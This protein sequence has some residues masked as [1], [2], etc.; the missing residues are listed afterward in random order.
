MEGLRSFVL[1]NKNGF[2][3][4]ILNWGATLT[5]LR[6][7]DREGIP[8]AVVIGFPDPATYLTNEYLQH[9]MYLGSS[10]GRFAGRIGHNRFHL[11]GVVCQLQSRGAHQLHGGTGGLS[12]RIWEL[13]AY[14][15]DRV[16]LKVVSPH[17]EGGYPG[18][19]AVQVEYR[20]TD[21]S[22][23]IDY[24]ATTD[25]ATVV[26]LT[27]HAYFNL[28]GGGGLYGDR[29]QIAA[30]RILETDKDLIPTGTILAVQD[31]EHDYR[32]DKKLEP[33]FVYLD[34]VFVLNDTDTK[35]T[36]ISGKSGIRMQV[37]TKQPGLVVYT[38][39]SMP[40]L[41]YHEGQIP[42]Q[43]GA[44]CFECQGFPDAPNKESFPS[45]R[46]MPHDTYKNSIRYRFD[47]Q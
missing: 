24:T 22:L 5:D 32:E 46:L 33:G 20:L 18:N 47:H 1:T 37:F 43:L 31:T 12:E 23:E 27:N 26:N 19:L 36:Y 28:S 16:T 9:T 2:Q 3:A 13:L 40:D 6:V 15:S 25:R 4:S 29:L 8:T 21:D 10:I 30:D 35:A 38:P 34:D 11:D 41:P 7:P 14:A 17:L 44:I 42:A 39:L 45:T